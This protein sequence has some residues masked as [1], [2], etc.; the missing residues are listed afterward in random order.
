MEVIST[1]PALNLYDLEWPIWTYQEQLPPAKFVFDEEDRR[2]IAVASMVSAGCIISGAVVRR[3]LLFSNVVVHDYSS[4]TDTVVLPEVTIGRHCT[5]NKCI[6]D[7]GCIIPDGMN[8]GLD[9]EQDRMRGF[10]VTEG[11]LVLVN[12]PML[13]LPVVRGT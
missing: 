8:I 9:H 5:I 1:S 11:G 10:R 7:R 13:G 4:V 2:G 6:I 12:R 3:S